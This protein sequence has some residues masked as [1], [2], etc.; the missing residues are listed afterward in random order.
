MILSNLVLFLGYRAPWDL[1]PTTRNALT[2]GPSA[3]SDHGNNSVK[4]DDIYRPETQMKQSELI[5]CMSDSGEGVSILLT[6]IYLLPLTYLFVQFFI[7]SYVR[8]NLKVKG[9]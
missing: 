7:R 1:A 9:N 4:G 6:T 8:V 5:P 3:P 2:A